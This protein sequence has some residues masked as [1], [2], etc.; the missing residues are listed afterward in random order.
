MSSCQTEANVQ[1]KHDNIKVTGQQYKINLCYGDPLTLGG[2]PTAN[3][4]GTG[5]PSITYNWTPTTALSD[6]NISNPIAT[7]TVPTIYKVVSTLTNN[8]VIC[9]DSSLF[10]V[11][12]TP[13][14]SIS[15]SSP[16]CSNDTLTISEHGGNATSWT[17]TSN[18][19][20]TIISENDF[21]SQ[22]VGMTDGEI[23]SFFFEADDGY[24]N[25]TTASI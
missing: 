21:S 3:W 1:I 16:V 15:S 8:G 18:G 23:F 17:W 19:N 22:V 5:N 7:P 24:S 9:K 11:N 25:T 14:V 4:S 6:P 20:A 10:Y 13:Q 12:V 2:S